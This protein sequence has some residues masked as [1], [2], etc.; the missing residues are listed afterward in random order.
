MWSAPSQ[1][2]AR[3]VIGLAFRALLIHGCGLNGTWGEGLDTK[4]KALRELN[5]EYRLKGALK[6]LKACRKGQIGVTYTTV[7]V[8]AID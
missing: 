4:K 8:L 5:N 7:L 3:N 1:R 2:A 6:P